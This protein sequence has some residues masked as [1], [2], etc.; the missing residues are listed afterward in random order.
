[1]ATPS[2]QYTLSQGDTRIGENR[3]KNNN[4]SYYSVQKIAQLLY[5][6]ML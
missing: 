6:F 3:L 5:E 1:M 2:W 4:G